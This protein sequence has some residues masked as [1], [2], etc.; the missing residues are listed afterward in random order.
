MFYTNIQSSAINTGMTSDYF[1]LERGVRQG[2][3][4]TPN[5]FILAVESLAISIRHNV[6]IKGIKIGNHEAKLL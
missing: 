6:D 5:L 4:L 2:D 1:T 3:P